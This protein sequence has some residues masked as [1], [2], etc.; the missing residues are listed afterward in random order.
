MDHWEGNE[1]KRLV[2]VFSEDATVSPY[3]LLLESRGNASFGP[4]S[5]DVA[6]KSLEVVQ[7]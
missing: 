4:L 2:Q 6:R 1:E 3:S 5:S 7:E